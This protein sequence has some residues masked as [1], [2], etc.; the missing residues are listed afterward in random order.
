MLK[1]FCRCGKLIP[2]EIKWCDECKIKYEYKKRNSNKEAYRKYKANRTDT[3]EQLFYVSDEWKFTRDSIKN[4]DKGVC[5]LCD[6]KGKGNFIDNVHHI[7]ELKDAWELRCS[8]GNLI[9]LCSRCHYYV[10]LKYKRSDEEKKQMQQT[11]L[12]LINR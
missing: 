5:V 11:L 10:H 8:F 3:K 6:S 2:Q 4:R 1:K 12:D 9:S 7:K